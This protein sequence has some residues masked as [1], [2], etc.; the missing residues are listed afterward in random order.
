M[1]TMSLPLV[2][3]IV[4]A[5]N[6]EDYLETAINSALKQS[7]PNI[8]IIV[9]DDGSTD[10]TGVIAD[11]FASKFPERVKV[12]HQENG[13]LCAA[14]NSAI[15]HAKG[16]YFAL[17]DADDEWLPHHIQNSIEAFAKHPGA[18]LVHSNVEL[19]DRSGSGL[20]SPKNKWRGSSNTNPWLEI[21][22]RREHVLCPTAVFKRQD[23]ASENYFDTHFN[24]LGCE[25][26]DLW[27][28]IASKYALVYLDHVHARYRLHAGN[29]SKQSEKMLEA[30]LRLVAKHEHAAPKQKGHALAA[31]YMDH[32]D[33]LLGAKNYF[34]AFN[35]NLKAL[36][37]WPSWRRPWKFPAKIVR[38]SICR[39]IKDE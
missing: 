19:M 21:F 15:R 25:D 12:V 37:Y 4:P 24:R 34:G 26:R 29:M 35:Y 1:L 8:E 14:R 27:L 6:A 39:L 18:A 13:G 30:R 7:Y 17:L 22:L 31:V 33:A 28:R 23:D 32:A 38:D 3:A 16:E 10:R 9:V 36:T 20:G 5:F 11:A 2:S